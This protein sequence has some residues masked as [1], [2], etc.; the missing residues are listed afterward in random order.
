MWEQIELNV[1]G[2]ELRTILYSTIIMISRVVAEAQDRTR[3]YIGIYINISYIATSCCCCREKI[4]LYL[5][6]VCPVTSTTRCL[7]ISGDWYHSS[8]PPLQLPPEWLTPHTSHLTPHTSHLT[9]HTSHKNDDN[10]PRTISCWMGTLQRLSWKIE[11]YFRKQN[12]AFQHQQ[13]FWFYNN[14]IF[15]YET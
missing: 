14:M 1:K 9:P 12:I 4:I 8:L 7:I 2:R 10:K 13:P 15:Q 5:S 11:Y 3:T 6:E